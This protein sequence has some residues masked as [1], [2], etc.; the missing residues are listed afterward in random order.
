MIDQALRVLIGLMMF[1]TVLAMGMGLS[2]AEVGRALR[3]ARILALGFAVNFVAI[4]ALV[5]L[6]VKVFAIDGPVAVGLLLCA[7]T[8]G[9]GVGTLFVDYARGDVGLSVGLL[10]GLT[11][12]SM[13]VTPILLGLW[14]GGDVGASLSATIWPMMR[15]ILTF[16]VAPLIAGLLL[17]HFAE[18]RTRKV[19]PWIA[20]VARWLMLGIIAAYLFT[21]G[22]LFFANGLRPF[23]ASLV[24][25]LASFLLGLGPLLRATRAER[26]SLGLT[27]MNRN[28][29][30]AMLLAA[31]FFTHPS[32]FAAVLAYGLLMLIVAFAIAA[33]FRRSTP[34][35]GRAVL[36]EAPIDDAERIAGDR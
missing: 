22:Q 9:G 33:W 24:A 12:S 21:Q 4:P 20:R 36:G 19:Q 35:L 1:L 23:V 34:A 31:T 3:R 7:L 18:S 10:L 27:S 25:I 5:L 14:T 11:F 15:L 2:F 8:P 26:V 30:L 29:A 13:V 32:T 6:L 17:R 16:Q 28:L